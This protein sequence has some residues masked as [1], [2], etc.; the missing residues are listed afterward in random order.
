MV[1]W[2]PVV[3]V[4]ASGTMSEDIPLDI[5]CLG[6]SLLDLT[7]RVFVCLWDLLGLEGID[8]TFR[9][10]SSCGVFL[11]ERFTIRKPEIVPANTPN[12]NSTMFVSI[13][14]SP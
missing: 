13:V 5:V 4:E 9:N 14:L 12:K 6:R 1:T 10:I 8:L 3:A 11:R 7:C 2:C